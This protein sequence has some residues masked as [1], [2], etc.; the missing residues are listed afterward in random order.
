MQI[1]HFKPYF[2]LIGLMV[3]ASL[4]LA[5]TV[6]VTLFDQPGVYMELPARIGAWQGDELRF[7]HN[8][9]CRPESD[10]PWSG[11]MSELEVPDICPECG[12]PLFKMSKAEYDQLP[13]DTEFVKS[14]YTNDTGRS[15]HVSIVLSG[16][17]RDSIHRPQRCLPGQGH[18]N[19]DEHDLIVPLQDGRELTVRIIESE[20]QYGT[21]EA[22]ERHYSYYAYWFVGQTR[23]TQSHYARMFWL[24]W[25]RVVNSVAHRWAY[26]AVSGKR[27]PGSRDYEEEARDFIAR[28]HDEIVIGVQN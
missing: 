21:R 7:C 26:I 10:F 27:E 18:R 23:E 6:D 19:L 17:A 13:K 24:A 5:F 4:A 25:D 22:P 2:I 8:E 20:V 1:S 11:K 16:M 28:L 14:S 9:N 12:G 15:V 3:L